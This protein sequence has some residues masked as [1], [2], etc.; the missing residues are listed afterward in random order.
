MPERQGPLYCSCEVQGLHTCRAVGVAAR[1]QGTKPDML[2][3]A[4]YDQ[5]S[6][7]CQLCMLIRQH[8]PACATCIEHHTL[9]LYSRCPPHAQ[10]LNA[11]GSQGSLACT[12]YSS[13]VLAGRW[14]LKKGRPQLKPCHGQ[15]QRVTAL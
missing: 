4:V 2:V 1:R 12:L 11:A 10:V 3:Q 15:H 8:C 7:A 5:I 9:H 13:M 6:K 14:P